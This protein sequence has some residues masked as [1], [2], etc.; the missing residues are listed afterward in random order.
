MEVRAYYYV[1]LGCI[2]GYIVIIGALYGRKPMWHVDEEVLKTV[3]GVHGLM[4]AFLGF[5]LGYWVNKGE[6]SW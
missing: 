4:G 3:Q 2:L 5:I 6:S 1:D